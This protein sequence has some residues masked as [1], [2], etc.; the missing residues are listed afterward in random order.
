MHNLENLNIWRKSIELTKLVYS[1]V[2]EFPS[3]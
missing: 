3:R 2:A 1:I